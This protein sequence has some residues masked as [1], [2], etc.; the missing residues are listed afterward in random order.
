MIHN[1][2]D[3]YLSILYT[4]FNWKG[5]WLICKQLFQFQF[6][7]IKMAEGGILGT[8][9]LATSIVLLRRIALFSLFCTPVLKPDVDNIFLEVKILC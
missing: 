8:S 9:E 2:G 4:R 7:N 5:D 1:E 3:N 6:V